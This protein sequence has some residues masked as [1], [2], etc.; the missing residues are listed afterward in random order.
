VGIGKQQLVQ[1]PLVV[2]GSAVHAVRA[3]ALDGHGQPTG[4]P[5]HEGHVPKG[6]AAQVT[7]V[8]QGGP[9]HQGQ[10][11]RGRGGRGVVRGGLQV[12]RPSSQEHEHGCET[13]LPLPL[14]PD[15]HTVTL[16][17]ASI[18]QR[19]NPKGEAG[20]C[21]AAWAGLAAR[22]SRGQTQNPTLDKREEPRLAPSLATQ[23]TPTP[24][25]TRGTVSLLQYSEGEAG[26]EGRAVAGRGSWGRQNKNTWRPPRVKKRA[27]EKEKRPLCPTTTCACH[28]A[29]PPLCTGAA[30]HGNAH[31]YSFR[32]AW[33]V[34]GRPR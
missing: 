21:R 4:G 22:H 2:D 5:V 26:D 1:P 31:Y 27:E 3:V 24:T 18:Q 28:H 23:N 17:P 30:H 34:H 14:A 11:A 15:Q 29:H 19:S 6:A 8:G 10:A 9:G 16:L 7:Q 33:H 25:T 12:R 32:Q 20:G 13:H